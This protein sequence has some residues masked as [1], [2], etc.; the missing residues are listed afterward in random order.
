MWWLTHSWL[1]R[2]AT[3]APDQLKCANSSLGSNLPSHR[4]A[5]LAKAIEALERAAEASQS[6]EDPRSLLF[7]AG[8]LLPV[9][10]Y[11]EGVGPRWTGPVFAYNRIG[12]A[13]S[14]SMF[15]LLQ[16]I[17]L[18]QHFDFFLFSQNASRSINGDTREIDFSQS[19][20]DTRLR[21]NLEASVERIRRRATGKPCRV[22]YG[23]GVYVSTGVS[24]EHAWP[25]FTADRVRC[26]E[27]VY[28]RMRCEDAL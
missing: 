5:V 22:L 2:S 28:L 10:V 3:P 26:E 6:V 21:A 11:P 19:G 7:R 24:L 25:L 16:R 13:G 12:K 18:V 4:A 27:A 9:H 8:R 15:K 1:K 20:Y 17:C 23:H 14:T